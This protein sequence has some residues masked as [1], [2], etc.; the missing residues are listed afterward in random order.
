MAYTPEFSDYQ[1]C[2]LRRIAWALDMPMTKAM[3][4]VFEHIGNF[5][6]NKRVCAACKDKSRCMLC[7]FNK[8]G[9][10]YAKNP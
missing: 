8:R 6:D 4:V 1:S 10:V 9:D 5:I 7:A 3:N 2:T